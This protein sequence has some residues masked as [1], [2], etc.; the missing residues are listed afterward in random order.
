M[1]TV[2]SCPP[3]SG[4]DAPV[5]ETSDEAGRGPRCARVFTRA[6]ASTTVLAW[7]VLVGAVVHPADG[8]GVPIC[9]S[10][11]V[12]G[13][14]CPGCGLTRSVSCAIRGDLSLSWHYHPFGAGILLL[15][16]VVA[17][18]GIL[19][20][21][22]RA[23]VAAWRKRNSRWLAALGVGYCAVLVAYGVARMMGLVGHQV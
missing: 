3:T 16:A 5:L 22:S 11:L 7:V 21:A 23:R 18:V 4:T 2:P 12:T 1:K 19:P 17:V 8:M 14:P 20:A 13:L 15:V 6:S 10:H 9:P